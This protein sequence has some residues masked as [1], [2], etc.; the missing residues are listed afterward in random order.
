MKPVEPF[1]IGGMRLVW[2]GNPEEGVEDLIVMLDQDGQTSRSMWQPTAGELEALKRGYPVI[3]E[4]QGRHP[5]VNLYVPWEGQLRPEVAPPPATV[6]G[7]PVIVD[8]G[9][10]SGLIHMRKRGGEAQGFA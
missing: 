5:P 9:A 7:V 10:T 6:F 4:V 3:L 2:T 1:G 8:D